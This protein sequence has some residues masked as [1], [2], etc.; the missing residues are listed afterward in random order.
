VEVLGIFPSRGEGPLSP[1]VDVN[2][3]AKL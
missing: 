3:L 2:I 1:K